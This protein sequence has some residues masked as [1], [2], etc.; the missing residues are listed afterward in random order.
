VFLFFARS[1]SGSGVHLSPIQMELTLSYVLEKGGG[2]LKQ[3]SYLHVGQR[4]RVPGDFP[5]LPHTS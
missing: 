1:V 3:A 5:L 2:K 4:L